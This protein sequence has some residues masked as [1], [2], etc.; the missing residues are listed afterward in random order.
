MRF[1]IIGSGIAGLGCAHILGPRHDVTLFEA[2][3]RLGGHANTVVVDDPD[4]GLIPVDTGFIVHNDRNY[5]NLTRLFEEL[6]IP[7]QDTEMSFAV[8][9]RGFGRS[10]RL[11]TYRATNLRTLFADRGNTIRPE[12]WRMLCDIVRFHGAAQRLLAE[13]E[14]D[15]HAIGEQAT[16]SDF[17]SAG[18]YSTVFIEGYLLPL[19][20]SVWSADPRTFGAFPAVSL[21]RFLRNHGLLSMGDRPQWRTIIGGSRI[22]VDAIAKRFTGT[23]RTDTPVVGI[24]RDAA[25]ATVRTRA[26]AERFDRV[27]LACHSDQALALLDDATV[28]EKEVLGAISYQPNVATLHTDTLMLSPNRAAWAAWNYECPPAGSGNGGGVTLTYDMTTLQ[29]LP[30]ARRYLVSLNSDYRIDPSCVLTSFTYAH[31]VFDG[32]AIEA[33]G[34]FDEIDGLGSTHFCGAYWGYGFHEDGIT[35]AVRV[36]RRLGVD[37]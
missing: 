27:I 35:S 5:P 29:N 11:F 37:W 18:R 10:G 19:G 36:C 14:A 17:L 26:G 9:D 30:G 3:G 16:L 7:V 22:Y 13:H 8:T 15:Q 24:T 33:Q 6:S 31:P 12:L 23:I 20:A 34:R 21:F 28:A 1:A 4:A 32:P 25:G 2:E